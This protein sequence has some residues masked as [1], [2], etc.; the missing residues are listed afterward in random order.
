MQNNQPIFECAQHYKIEDKQKEN[1]ITFAGKVY[2]K[3]EQKLISTG[4]LIKELAK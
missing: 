4:H 3:S 2:N 1:R